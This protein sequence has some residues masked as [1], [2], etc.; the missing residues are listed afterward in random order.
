VH[1]ALRY[2]PSLLTLLFG[3]KF[4]TRAEYDQQAGVSLVW[5]RRWW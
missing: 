1:K 3:S 5:S 2:G 4:Y